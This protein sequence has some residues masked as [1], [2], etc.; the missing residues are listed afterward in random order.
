[1]GSMQWQ[2]GRE[3]GNIPAFASRTQENQGNLGR[4]GRSQDLPD[5]GFQPDVRHLS[6]VAKL[7]TD[8]NITETTYS[9]QFQYVFVN[10]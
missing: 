1:M 7:S 6:Q 4:D 2:L 8:I 3:M 9:C 5:S 10:Q